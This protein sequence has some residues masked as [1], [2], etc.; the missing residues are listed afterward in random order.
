[1]TITLRPLGKNGPLVPAIGFGLM[2]MTDTKYGAVPEKDA[3]LALLDRAVEIGAT[4]WDTSDLYGDNE[5]LLAQWFKR[6]GKRDQIF[7]ASK[8]GYVRGSKTMEIDTSYEACKNACNMTL[9]T[10]E[11]DH[12]DLYYVHNVDTVTPIE[13]TMR[14]LVELQTEGKIK[15]IGLSMVSSNTLRRAVKV[16]PVAAYQPEYSLFDRAIEGPAGTDVLATCRELGIAVVCATPLGRGILTSTF[17]QGG[18]IGDNTDLRGKMLPRFQDGAREH[19][20][21]LAGKIK[22]IAD[23]KGC[24]LSQLALAWLLKQGDDIF[25]IPGTRRVKYLEENMGAL[26]VS[27]SDEEEAEMRAIV[28]QG[29]VSGGSVP[30]AFAAYIFRD[31]KSE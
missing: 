25:P 5:E 8:F 17:S 15:H 22:T 19:N 1:M 27:L 26:G 28:D 6:S 20:A 29:H 30:D 24:S 18:A 16:A 9:D 7:L 4:F 31:T 2:M 3:R 21:N 13:Q 11:I 23:R 12:L 14:A 10:M